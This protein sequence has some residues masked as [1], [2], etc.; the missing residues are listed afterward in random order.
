MAADNQKTIGLLALTFIGLATLFFG[1]KTMPGRL[2]K[3]FN[4][5]PAGSSGVDLSGNT[6]AAD[7][8][9]I[10]ALKNQDTDH[11]GLND[12]DEASIYKTSPYIADSDSDD[13]NDYDEIKNGT[14]PNC[15]EGQ[16][17]RLAA[18]N[19]SS[20]EAATPN[21]LEQSLLG[22]LGA[23]NGA[24]SGLG[25]SELNINLSPA[26]L[27][28]LL[29]ENGFSEDELKNIDDATLTKLWQDSLKQNTG[30]SGNGST[31]NSAPPSPAKA[32][33]ATELRQMLK[34][35]GTDPNLLEKVS[36]AE[37]VK[38]YSEIVMG[39]R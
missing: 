11:D 7:Q 1:I 8:A 16:D 29:K 24:V 32:P 31:E 4:L 3:P 38:M 28:S 19:I 33:T 15:P 20:A 34:D 18:G 27:R 23:V 36:D 35:A 25:A 17:C 14:D 10:L 21:G 12:Y 37:L 26:D 22:P 9:K 13:A 5:L 2:M 39:N 6:D 30:A